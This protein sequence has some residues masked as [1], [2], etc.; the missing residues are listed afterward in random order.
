VVANDLLDRKELSLASP[1]VCHESCETVRWALPSVATTGNPTL[2][3]SRGCYRMT[4]D[5]K[6]YRIQLHGLPKR[7]EI[8]Q[9]SDDETFA[10]P[11]FKNVSRKE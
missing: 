2:E 11:L 1:R 6:R 5:I 3:M 8:S 4:Q 9:P 7:A 10:Q